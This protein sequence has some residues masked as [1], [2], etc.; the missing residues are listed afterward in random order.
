[1]PGKTQLLVRTTKF[2]TPPASIDDGLF[3]YA[4]ES[5]RKREGEEKGGGN[6]GESSSKTAKKEATAY[7]IVFGSYANQGLKKMLEDV[8]VE[9]TF[10]SSLS[11]FLHP[12]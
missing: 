12:S 2:R 3:M 8:P 10:P 1:M 6:E 4:E 7:D 11:L 5:K 9:V